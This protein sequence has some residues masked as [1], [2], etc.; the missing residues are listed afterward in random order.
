MNS[1]LARIHAS[2]A[3][4]HAMTNCP[5]T[6]D[7]ERQPWAEFSTRFVVPFGRNL[8]LASCMVACYAIEDVEEIPDEEFPDWVAETAIICLSDAH[9]ELW[10]EEFVHGYP[11]DQIAADFL[12][13]IRKRIDNTFTFAAYE[14]VTGRGRERIATHNAK[15]NAA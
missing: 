8:I 1:K 3:G 7:E 2:H 5:S 15:M 11:H 13:Y 4:V 10:S 6:H 12:A 9:D 14:P